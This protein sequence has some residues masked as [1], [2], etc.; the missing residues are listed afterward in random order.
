MTYGAGAKPT[1]LVVDDDAGMRNSLKFSLQVE[2]FAVCAY[3]SGDDL[4]SESA[5]PTHACIIVDE[6]MSGITGLDLLFELRQR[7]ISSPAVLIA[8]HP[9]ERTRNR[10]AAAG[11]QVIEKPLFGD[12]L[13]RSIWE[14]LRSDASPDGHACN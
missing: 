11:A 4:L 6:D 2:G 7:E 8:S 1:I 9:T 10:A 3:A 12:T 5:L 14:M 13:M